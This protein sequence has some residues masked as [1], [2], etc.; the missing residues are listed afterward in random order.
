MCSWNSRDLSQRT[1]KLKDRIAVSCTSRHV[2]QLFSIVFKPSSTPFAHTFATVSDYEVWHFFDR[3]V[4]LAITLYNVVQQIQSRPTAFSFFFFDHKRMR[5]IS[6]PLPPPPPIRKMMRL[7]QSA[8]VRCP[9][10]H[11]VH[12]E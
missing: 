4:V 10:K 3:D 7:K 9:L 1:K 8:N 12:E 5:P 6:L 11:P 2:F